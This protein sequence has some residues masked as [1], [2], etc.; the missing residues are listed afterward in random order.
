L[1]FFLYPNALD[2]NVDS[3]FK[4][5]YILKA[6]GLKGEV[7]MSPMPDCPDLEELE[8]V[9]LQIREQLVPYILDSVN[10]KKGTK[11]Y[12]RL[13]GID[14]PEKAAALKGT[15]IYVPKSIR[16]S[17]PGNEFYSDEVIDFEVIDIKVGALGTIKEVQEFGPGKHLIVLVNGKEV[18]I[19]VNSPFIK[20]INK[21][22][23]QL[24][25][26]L[27]DGFLEL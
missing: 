13:E 6:H 14:T 21:S 3:C 17:L 19:P 15:S 24:T 23:K 12:L 5:G 1:A 10:I 18:M 27:P 2:M 16:P 7:T 22:G 9:F 20:K 25:V 8:S 4:I 11:A 26:E